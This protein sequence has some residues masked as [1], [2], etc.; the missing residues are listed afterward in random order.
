MNNIIYYGFRDSISLGPSPIK[1]PVIQEIEDLKEISAGLNNHIDELANLLSPNNPHF[2]F[3]FPDYTRPILSDVNLTENFSLNI[4]NVYEVE[5]MLFIEQVEVFSSLSQNLQQ[6]FLDKTKDFP[7]PL[8][9]PELWATNQK[10]IDRTL[11]LAHN[12]PKNVANT[13]QTNVKK[14]VTR[15]AFKSFMNKL[16]SWRSGLASFQSSYARKFSDITNKLINLQSDLNKKLQAQTSVIEDLKSKYNEKIKE[17]NSA[18]PDDRDALLEQARQLN[19]TIETQK[20][21][22]NEIP[23]PAGIELA[24]K[25]KPIYE[26]QTKFLNLNFDSALRITTLVQESYLG[27]KPVTPNWAKKISA[28]AQ[29]AENKLTSILSKVDI[30]KV[31]LNNDSNVS[32]NDSAVLKKSEQLSILEGDFTDTGYARYQSNGKFGFMDRRGNIII[33]AK[34]EEA[35]QPYDYP[36]MVAVK[37]NGKWGYVII[38]PVDALKDKKTGNPEYFADEIVPPKYEEAA[39]HTVFLAPVKLNGK[40]GYID[41]T[42][43]EVT[44]FKYDFA[45]NL[46]PGSWLAVVGVGEEEVRK[47]GY[48]DKTGVEVI[49]PQYEKAW[50]FEFF[51][52]KISRAGVRLNGLW[53]FIDAQGTAVIPLKYTKIEPFSNGLAQVTLNDKLIYIDFFGNETVYK[54]LTK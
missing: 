36:V 38:K 34:Y 27:G 18:L 21:V 26:T 16:D 14:P 25:L 46:T 42:G 54:K 10:V 5:P 24:D 2:A 6:T 31:T 12:P 52:D 53:G 20:A 29:A 15:S 37:L 49:P 17:V 51:S 9:G 47:Y 7:E 13:S 30:K 23:T 43:K 28:S 22:L 33:E 45:G 32:N 4:D 8:D 19:S 41:K 3:I 44:S 1:K 48:I 11:E 35:S 50:Q 40:W 39:P